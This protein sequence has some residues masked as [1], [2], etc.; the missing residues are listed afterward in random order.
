[1]VQRSH[2]NGRADQSG[3]AWARP[4][5]R[6]RRALRK[7]VLVAVALGIALTAAETAARLLRVDDRMMTGALLFQ[8]VDYSVHRESPDWFLHYELAPGASC[9]CS[10]DQLPPYRVHIDEFGARF[11]T[12]PGAKPS[13]TFR[14]LFFGGSTMYGAAVNDE[15]TMPAAV[16]RLLNGTVTSDSTVRPRHFEAWNFGTHA[17]VLSQAAHRA[18]TELLLRDPDLIVVQLHNIGPRG[19]ILAPGADPLDYLDRYAHDPHVVAECF[20]APALI[21]A[22]VHFAALRFSALYRAA[23]GLHRRYDR[24][25]IDYAREV[26]RNEARALVREADARGIPVV[27]MVLPGDRGWSLGTDVYPELPPERVVQLYEPGREGA[28]YELHPPAPIL[29]QYAA[30]LISELRARRVLPRE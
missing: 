1:M 30:K 16:E 12:H 8:Q 18:R 10:Y 15:E 21:P 22:P 11:P 9:D 24:S 27:F 17:Y 25:N 6:R 23:T 14:I 19:F 13:G 4:V 5:A 3:V 28:F 20:P 7:I 29:E 2:S 26:S